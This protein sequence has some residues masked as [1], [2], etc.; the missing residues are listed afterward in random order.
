MQFFNRILIK[1]LS[2]F[3]QNFPT[4]CVFRPNAEKN[5]EYFGKFFWELCNI[6]HFSNFSKKFLEKFWKIFETFPKF[7]FSYKRGKNYRKVR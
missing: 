5:N 1:K 3:S 2:N 7:A 6:M 4:I